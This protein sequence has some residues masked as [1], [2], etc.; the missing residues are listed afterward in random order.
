MNCTR[1]QRPLDDNT[2]GCA[3]CGAL[4]VTV[5]GIHAPKISFEE[6]QVWQPPGKSG[7]DPYAAWPKDEAPVTPIAPVAPIAPAAPLATE[8]GHTLPEQKV[9]SVTRLAGYLF[10]LSI[11]VV[12][13]PIACVWAFQR[14]DG[15]Q[16][17]LA[18]AALLLMLAKWAVLMGVLL[19]LIMGHSP[20]LDPLLDILR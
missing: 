6:R 7:T 2:G 10:I 13:F 8:S 9:M 18:R 17:N 14:K 16:K 1:C 19:W 11:P 3:Y 12:N 20:I 5:A 4:S 15:I